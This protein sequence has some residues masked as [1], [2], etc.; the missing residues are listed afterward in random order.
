MHSNASG[1]SVDPLVSASI[2]AEGLLDFVFHQGLQPFWRLVREAGLD[3]LPWLMRYGRR[4]EHWKV[5]LHASPR[6][7]EALRGTLTRC[8]QG[9]FSMLAGGSA[10]SSRAFWKD[11][12]PLDAEDSTPD[13]QPDRS[14]LWTSYRRHA[15]TFGPDPFPRD[16]RWVERFIHTLSAGCRWLLDS[17]RPGEDGAVPFVGRQRSLLLLVATALNGDDFSLEETR[18]YLAYHR[19]TLIRYLLSNSEVDVDA[20]V[21]QILESFSRQTAAAEPMV[22]PILSCRRIPGERSEEAAL[23]PWKSAFREAVKYLDTVGGEDDV[24]SLDP[25]AEQ[26]RFP[27]VFKLFHGIANIIGMT[28]LSEACAFHLLLEALGDPR[29]RIERVLLIPEV[30]LD[31]VPFAESRDARER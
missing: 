23:L 6:D 21:A 3:C 12:P 9:A 26:S 20:K 19:D 13:L 10:D 30:N 5:R 7:E 28:K 27:L 11:S 22:T 25:F 4:G 16:D 17:S 24:R 15:L 18:S 2:Y 14:L 1:L 8:T 29:G 31:F